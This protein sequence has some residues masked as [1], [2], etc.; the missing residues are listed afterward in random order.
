METDLHEFLFFLDLLLRSIEQLVELL[1]A[2]AFRFGVEYEWLKLDVG[3]C[4][5]L[6]DCVRYE[7]IS[8]VRVKHS[9]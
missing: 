2:P 3:P 7:V 9:Y 8:S 4:S 1:F 6:P 5:K